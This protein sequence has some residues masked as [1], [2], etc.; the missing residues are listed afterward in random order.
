MTTEERESVCVVSE[1][2][3]LHNTALTVQQMLLVSAQQPNWVPWPGLTDSGGGAGSLS[4]RTGY[5]LAGLGQ[6]TESVVTTHYS[7]AYNRQ[8][9]TLS[10]LFLTV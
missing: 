9:T 1:V 10:R 4:S 8:L 6:N 7:P 3:A 5:S 2:A